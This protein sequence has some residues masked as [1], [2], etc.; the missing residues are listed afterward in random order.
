VGAHDLFSVF[1]TRSTA[2]KPKPRPPLKNQALT[3]PGK[4]PHN[5][6]VIVSDSLNESTLYRKK[7]KKSKPQFERLLKGAAK[8]G[9][10]DV[11]CGGCVKEAYKMWRI[12]RISIAWL[13]GMVGCASA[14]E[15]ASFHVP[16]LFTTGYSI[17]SARWL[18]ATNTCCW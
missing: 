2:Y 8:S 1:S 11:G 15:L 7:S 5:T 16:F 10:F 14:I 9:G 17:A 4:N 13:F 6:P 12:A 3:P 18:L